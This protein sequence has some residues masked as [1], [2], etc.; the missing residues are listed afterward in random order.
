MGLFPYCARQ[1]LTIQAI[2]LVNVFENAFMLSLYG[3]FAIT[4]VLTLYIWRK[5]FK[6][7]KAIVS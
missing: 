6:S 5:I 3:G 2:D 4:A 1:V 7:F